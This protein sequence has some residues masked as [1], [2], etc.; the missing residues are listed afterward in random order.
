MPERNFVE[1]VPESYKGDTIM[2]TDGDVNQIRRNSTDQVLEQEENPYS[3]QEA[4]TY[5]ED[6]MEA[7]RKYAIKKEAEDSDAIEQTLFDKV[8]F[9]V[10]ITFAV[11]LLVLLIYIVG[12]LAG[13]FG[14][15]TVIS[16][17][18]TETNQEESLNQKQTVMPDVLG[19][20]KEEAEA[21]LKENGLECSIQAQREYSEEYPED[22]ICKQEFKEGTVVNKNTRVKLVL[23]LGNKKYQISDKLIGMTK[24]ELEEE[25]EEYEIKN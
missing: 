19:K 7:D 3:E 21:L 18:S 9:W 10:G 6:S 22:T 25:L 1:N 5:M 17:R 13:W 16:N 12:T 20:T 15:M 2:I 11:I 4:D 24:K 8:I 23:S 14:N